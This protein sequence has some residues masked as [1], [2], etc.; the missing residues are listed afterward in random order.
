MQVPRYVGIT[1]SHQKRSGTGIVE[2]SFPRFVLESA[3]FETF[4]NIN[5]NIRQLVHTHTRIPKPVSKS[6]FVLD[7]SQVSNM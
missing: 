6:T 5:I 2:G 1:F 7:T 4:Y 3:Q